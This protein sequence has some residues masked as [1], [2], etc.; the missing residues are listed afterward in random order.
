[1]LAL[2]RKGSH[3]RH[4]PLALGHVYPSW[5]SHCSGTVAVASWPGLWRKWYQPAFSG[6]KTSSPAPRGER[7]PPAEAQPRP[8]LAPKPFRLINAR[9]SLL[10]GLGPRMVSEAGCAHSQIMTS[11]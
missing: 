6:W 1:M 5:N 3:N 11:A 10:C 4:L 7:F 9:P 2:L 8:G